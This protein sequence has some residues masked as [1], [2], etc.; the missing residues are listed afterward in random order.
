MATKVGLPNFSASSDG[1]S[2]TSALV[3]SAGAVATTAFFWVMSQPRTVTSLT[4]ASAVTVA[5][6]R[7]RLS[8]CTSWSGS[9]AL[10]SPSPGAS[11]ESVGGWKLTLPSSTTSTKPTSPASEVRNSASVML[12][13]ATCGDGRP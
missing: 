9:W 11:A 6:N 3:D 8:P 2:P 1:L 10:R 12:A 7:S 5:L 13:W 4:W